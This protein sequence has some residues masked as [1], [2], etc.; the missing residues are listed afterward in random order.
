MVIRA[1]LTGIGKSTQ[2]PLVSRRFDTAVEVRIESEAG[3][4][5]LMP[6]NAEGTAL[7]DQWYETVEEAKHAAAVEF[8]SQQLVWE[9]TAD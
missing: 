2:A 9:P 6:L 4:W 7:W 5:L 8:E 3:G 1:R